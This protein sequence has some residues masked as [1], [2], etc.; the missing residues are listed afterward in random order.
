[1]GTSQQLRDF[2]IAFFDNVAALLAQSEHSSAYATLL[3]SELP[4]VLTT[5]DHVKLVPDAE[6]LRAT[7]ELH[8]AC[9]KCGPKDTTARLGALLERLEA[10]KRNAL[11][12]EG[13]SYRPIPLLPSPVCQRGDE[14]YGFHGAC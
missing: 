4:G 9:K 14:P 1:M 8:I 5:A 13:K 10:A 6:L 11:A 12:A 7:R 3:L 2:L